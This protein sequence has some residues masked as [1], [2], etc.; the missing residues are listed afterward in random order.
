MGNDEFPNIQDGLSI[1]LQLG[2]YFIMNFQISK[3][4]RWSFNFPSIRQVFYNEFPNIQDIQDGLSI[5]LQ[6]GKY[7]IM[8]FQI[9]KT[10]F[11]PWAAR[12]VQFARLHYFKKIDKIQK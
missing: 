2:K 12:Y 5:S 10:F 3:Y 6:L 9:F 11:R 8:N 1:S 4:S 7:F